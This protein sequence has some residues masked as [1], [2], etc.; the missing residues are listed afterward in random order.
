MKSIIDTNDFIEHIGNKYKSYNEKLLDLILFAS[1]KS[2][3]H[4]TLEVTTF[5]DITYNII[6]IDNE[7]ISETYIDY[8]ID[9]K[10]FIISTK[11]F[12]NSIITPETMQL[13]EVNMNNLK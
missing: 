2:K 3:Q 5:N 6:Y 9:N 13:I 12:F 8:T 4:F 7:L 10:N 11:L 1:G